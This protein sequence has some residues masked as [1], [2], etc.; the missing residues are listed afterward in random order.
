MCDSSSAKKTFNIGNKEC[1]FQAMNYTGICWEGEGNML[2]GGVIDIAF[3]VSPSLSF[4][5]TV[6]TTHTS[7]G[8]SSNLLSL[9][10]VVSPLPTFRPRPIPNEDNERVT[11]RRGKEDSSKRMMGERR[12][13]NA[14]PDVTINSA[15]EKL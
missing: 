8:P 1:Y 10:R 7:L 4:Q 9:P 14:V 5:T 13:S 12:I 3:N 15:G 6:F 11:N 2:A